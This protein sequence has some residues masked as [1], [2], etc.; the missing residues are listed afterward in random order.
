MLAG[1]AQ[2]ESTTHDVAAS[3]LAGAAQAESTTHDV[4][5]SML[6]GAARAES[7]T[8]DA[9]AS[10]LAGAARAES[11][12]HDAAASTL[13]G[14]ARAESTTHNAAARMLAGAARAERQ[15]GNKLLRTGSQ[16]AENKPAVSIEICGFRGPLLGPFLGPEIRPKPGPAE[17]RNASSGCVV[18]ALIIKNSKTQALATSSGAS[19]KLTHPTHRPPVPTAARPDHPLRHRKAEPEQFF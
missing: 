11:T 8:H 16:Q 10:I 7:T 17:L 18:E 19:S 13:A 5:A 3:M 6:A 9:A 15:A 14:A 12:T 4:A 2:P 1:A